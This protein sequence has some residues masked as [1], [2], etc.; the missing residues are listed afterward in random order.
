MKIKSLLLP[1]LLLANLAQAE[2]S[3]DNTKEV[4]IDDEKGLM[5]QDNKDVKLIQKDWQRAKSYC[6]DLNLGGYSDW[7]L[8]NIDEMVST[9]E[10]SKYA[11]SIAADFKN[12]ID[13]DYWTSTDM[14]G[15]KGLIAW[16]IFFGQDTISIAPGHKMNKLYIRCVRSNMN[17]K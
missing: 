6:E 4:V 13:N 9:A 2:M 7:R 10:A 12:T 3:R 15:N 11:I 1:L 17:S 5:W 16:L 14:Q 8:P